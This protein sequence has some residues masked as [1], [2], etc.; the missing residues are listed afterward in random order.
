MD[1]P[2]AGRLANRRHREPRN[3][4][5]WNLASAPNKGFGRVLW[6]IRPVTF[7]NSWEDR[8]SP[9]PR[10]YKLM[11]VVAQADP[12][13]V[14]R[15]ILHLVSCDGRARTRIGDDVAGAGVAQIEEAVA[16]IEMPAAARLDN[17]RI[18][19]AAADMTCGR[20]SRW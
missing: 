19:D 15:D 13:L 9:A 14:R 18:L 7:L 17:G 16:G 2:R 4:N 20:R 1:K 5:T 6:A 8:A 3:T 12:Q 11:N 10:T